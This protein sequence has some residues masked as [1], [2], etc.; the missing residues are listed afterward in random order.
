MSKVAKYRRQVSEDPDIDSL[1]STLS[2]EE[3]E[4]LEKELDVVDSDGSI[5]AE[6]KQADVAP[7]GTQNCDAVLNHH[8]KEPRKRLQREQAVDVSPG[9]PRCAAPQARLCV[10]AAWRGSLG[11][12]GQAGGWGRELAARRGFGELS[13]S[14]SCSHG[15]SPYLWAGLG[16]SAASA[17]CGVTEGRSWLLGGNHPKKL[18]LL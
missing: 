15:A 13:E 11:G 16:A 1:L 5:P 2:P 8:G 10:G 7:G 12:G 17:P 3:M 18:D 4:E 6:Q 9:S 14:Q